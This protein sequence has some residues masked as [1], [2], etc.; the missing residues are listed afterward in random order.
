MDQKPDRFEKSIRFGCGSLLGLLLAT[1]M[2]LRSYFRIDMFNYIFAIFI[3]LLFG[4][5]AMKYGDQFWD[6]WS[7][8]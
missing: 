5:L 6:F 8:H 7:R 2:L 3:V 4:L 1:H